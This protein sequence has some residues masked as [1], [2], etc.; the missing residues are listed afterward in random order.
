MSISAS[1][2]TNDRVE[3]QFG[4]RIV[5]VN[6]REAIPVVRT[7]LFLAIIGCLASA[8]DGD[9]Q[10]RVSQFESSGDLAGARS[11]LTQQATSS[12]DSATAQTLA[13]F[14]CRH[15]DPGCRDAT[16]TPLVLSAQS[17]QPSL[18]RNR[19]T[20]SQLPSWQPVAYCGLGKL[21]TILPHRVRHIPTL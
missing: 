6:C 18:W 13:E 17:R 1:G 16:A 2:S 9:L 14:L 12:N 21:L 8:A 4:G 10:S 3:N 15:A 7:L 19:H 11:F 20:V 5:I